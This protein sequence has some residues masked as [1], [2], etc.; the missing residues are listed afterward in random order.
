MLQASPETSSPPCSGTVSY[1]HLTYGDEIIGFYGANN[2]SGDG[3]ALAVKNAN[4]SERIVSA[5]IDS[6]D[7]E[8]E[9]LELGN[10]DAIIV[11][12]P[13]K[14]AYDATMD[15]YNVLIE[16]KEMQK[17]VNIPCTIVTKENM[18]EDAIKALLN[19]PVSYTHLDVYK[20][21]TI[22]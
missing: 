11:Q 15:V 17:V 1:T 20:R 9:A 18:E 5:A 13:Y 21:Q 19:P 10:L 8:I 3:I 22:R 7:L 12:D 16:G 6:D 2:I 4:I 14:T